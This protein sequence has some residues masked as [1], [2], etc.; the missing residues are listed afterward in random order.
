MDQTNLL[1]NIIKFNNKSK[2]VTKEGKDKKRN[3]FDSENTLSEGRELTLNA[4]KSRIFP[5]IAAQG[6]R[7]PWDLAR[8]V[9]IFDQTWLKIFSPK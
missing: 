8:V 4:I 9:N 7:C 3:I 5:N 6:K 2:P 1:E